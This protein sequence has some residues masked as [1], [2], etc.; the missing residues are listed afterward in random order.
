M[1]GEEFLSLLEKH[2]DYGIELKESCV[3]FNTN[4]S[5]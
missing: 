2:F 3:I 4:K 1:T 5:L